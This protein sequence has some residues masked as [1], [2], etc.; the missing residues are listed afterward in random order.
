MSNLYVDFHVLQT[1]PPSCINRDDMGSPK[2]AEF[3]GKRRAR[4]SSQSWKRAM[5][6]AFKG[7]FTEDQLGYQTKKMKNLVAK[8]ITEL[9][10]NYTMEAAEKLA[11][12]ELKE[13]N[14]GADN[15]LFFISSSQVEGL[16]R[17]I[18]DTNDAVK[19]KKKAKDIKSV[20]LKAALA[21][22][23]SIDICLFG[24]MSA[25]EA[26]LTVEAASQVA[27]AISTHA[28]DNQFDYYTA[29]DDCSGEEETGSGFL[30]T[31]EFNS[32]TLYRYANVNVNELMEHLSKEEA[33]DAVRGFAEAFIKSMPTGKQNSFANRTLP[34]MVYVT[35]RTDQP[36]NMVSA[37]EKP[38][39]AGVNGY[40]AGSKKA[41]VQY[42]EEMY[43]DWL[44]KPDSVWYVGKI[45][46]E[47]AESFGTKVTLS[48]LLD[49]L[50]K[51]LTNRL[52]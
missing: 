30:G 9:D 27:H 28:V 43:E 49:S 16:A 44:P 52:S 34:D 41:F 12:A 17:A 14:L 35:V 48:E 5:K 11:E 26:S 31:T 20:S 19:D 2:T 40:M 50:K 6:E 22:N 13:A 1:V 23:P 36:V 21:E 33:V 8:K 24:R 51:D 45:E 38:V 10:S 47:K 42:T 3:G 39:F 46:E 15:V 25:G 29:V 7:I 32:S 4:V 18:L 37:F